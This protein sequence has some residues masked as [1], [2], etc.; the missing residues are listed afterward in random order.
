MVINVTK[1]VLNIE[2]MASSTAKMSNATTEISTPITMNINEK[3]FNIMNETLSDIKMWLIIITIIIVKI[4]LIK[5]LKTCKRTY[6]MHNETV[7]RRHN[8]TTPQMTH[9]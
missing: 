9:Q 4:V 7:I 5:L 3:D 1:S 2:K 6:N 8:R